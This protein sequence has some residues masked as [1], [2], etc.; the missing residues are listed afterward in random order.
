MTWQPARANS[1]PAIIP[2]G[3][4]PTTIRSS[5]AAFSADAM[6]PFRRAA[7]QPSSLGQ[8]LGLVSGLLSLFGFDEIFGIVLGCRDLVA[9]DR[10]FRRQLLHDLPVR[11]PAMRA[12]GNAIS[13]FQYLGHKVLRMLNHPSR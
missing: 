2:A 11:L 1:I 6:P 7:K 9:L 3:P 13:G 10:R 12:P 5:S 4:P 8:R